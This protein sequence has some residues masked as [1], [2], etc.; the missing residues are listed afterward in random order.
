LSQPVIA[1]LFLYG[2]I[3]L[4][5]AAAVWDAVTLTIPNYLVLAVLALYAASL[6]VNFELSD[7]LYDLLAAAIVF[8]VCFVLFALGWL[9]GGDAKL[10]PGAV[11]W[12][13]YDGFLAFVIAMTLAG[14]ILTIAL[15]ILRTG[16]RAAGASQERLPLALQRVSPVPYGIAISAGAILVIWLQN[17]NSLFL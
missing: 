17:G 11:L 12:A 4:L 6:T 7:F 9:G 5:V 1:T 15:L 3:L 8:A 13:D 2:A 10:A 16:L 14:G